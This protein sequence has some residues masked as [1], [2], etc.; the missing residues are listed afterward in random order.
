MTA[1][2]GRINVRVEAA[3]HRRALVDAALREMGSTLA[4]AL[5]AA[6]ESC[7]TEGIAFV[8]TMRVTLAVPLS[9]I[10]GRELSRVIAQACVD[11]AA[12]RTNLVDAPGAGNGIAEVIARRQ[13]DS[14]GIRCSS[15]AQEAA[16]WLVGMVLDDRNVLR[17]ASPFSDLEHL[18]SAKAFAAV[19]ARCGDGHG[20]VRALGPRWS[21]LLAERA[22]EQDASTLLELL[23]DGETPTAETWRA[24]VALG[25]EPADRGSRGALLR[26]LDLLHDGTPGAVAAVR[27]VAQAA[28]AELTYQTEMAGL[29]LLLPHLTCRIG[30]VPEGQ[31]RALVLAVAERLGGAFADGDPA[32]DALCGD[33]P[34]SRLRAARPESARVDFLAVGAIRDFARGF[35][36][37]ERARS[38][39]ILRNLLRGPATVRLDDLGWH[40][41]LPRAPL[42]VLLERA[43]LI[44]PVEVPWREPRLWI[45]RDP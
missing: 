4:D 39:Y 19:G 36:H 33:E 7:A 42:R 37:F 25:R 20:L 6:A 2:V 29:W 22:D 18:P 45:E 43:A 31:A 17:R 28:P 44:G 32:I 27:T 21:R 9:N 30:T 34:R 38:A 41:T 11:A 8:P 16:A 14:E 13:H 23:D 35:A 40:A 12:H 5:A 24:T 1:N 15:A 10:R 26:A 3:P